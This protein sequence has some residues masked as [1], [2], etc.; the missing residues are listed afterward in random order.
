[1]DGGHFARRFRIRFFFPTH[2]FIPSFRPFP[3]R[4]TQTYAKKKGIPSGSRV[5]SEE[6][7]VKRSEELEARGCEIIILFIATYMYYIGTR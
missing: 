5:G 3:S 6:G 4:N 1:M 7:E 2:T